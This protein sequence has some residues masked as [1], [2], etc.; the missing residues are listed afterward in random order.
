MRNL[1]PVFSKRERGQ[2]LTELAVSFTLLVIIL[3]VTVDLGRVF[4]S[5]IAVR[6]AAEEGAL[7]GS[8]NPQDTGG[9]TQRAR[10]S[11]NAPVDLTN[12]SNVAVQVNVIGSPCAGNSLRVTVTYTYTLTM[13]FVSSFIGTQSFPLTAQATSAILRPA[14]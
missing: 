8:L 14:C 11:S 10:Q 4:F 7:Y 1:E 3:A 2:S 6:E 12:T 9:I 5:F 13:P